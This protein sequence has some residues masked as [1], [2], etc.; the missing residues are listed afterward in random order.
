MNGIKN[1]CFQNT[2]KLVASTVVYAGLLS[3]EH[4]LFAAI[5]YLERSLPERLLCL[6]VPMSYEGVEE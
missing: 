5:L 4:R 6:S 1:E 3:L 2:A